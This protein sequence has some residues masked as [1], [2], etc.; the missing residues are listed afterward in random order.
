MSQISIARTFRRGDP[1]VLAPANFARGDAEKAKMAA[2]DPLR[3]AANRRRTPSIQ[4]DQR[5]PVSVLS[6]MVYRARFAGLP[7]QSQAENR[8]TPPC[9][10][11]RPSVTGRRCWGTL[12]LLRHNR[13]ITPMAL[14]WPLRPWR[15]M[16]CVVCDTGLARARCDRKYCSPAC[17]QRHYRRRK[18]AQS[19]AARKPANLVAAMMG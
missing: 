12:L 17:R 18:S 19:A 2:A 1:R 6:S 11:A 13:A 9:A 15:E 4:A 7:A 16:R 8:R 10:C 14:S 5:T 3:T